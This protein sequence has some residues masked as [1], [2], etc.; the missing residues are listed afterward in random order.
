MATQANSMQASIW[1]LAAVL[2]VSSAAL[3]ADFARADGL[4]FEEVS[5]RILAS[6]ELISSISFG[7]RITD[8]QG[9]F[10]DLTIAAKS[11]CFYYCELGHGGPKFDVADDYDRQIV[12]VLEDRIAKY[13]PHCR[14]VVQEPFA[15]G[16]RLPGTL[17]NEIFLFATGIWPLKGRE[18]S[19]PLGHAHGLVDIASSADFTVQ[20]EAKEVSG[21]TC[22]LI[23]HKSGQDRLWVDLERGCC[24]TRREFYG[25]NGSS[26]SSLL[27]MTRHREVVPGVWIPFAIRNTVF[28]ASLSGTPGETRTSDF[29]VSIKYAEINNV[30]DEQFHFSPP[31]GTLEIL[32]EE[33]AHKTR[34]LVSGGYDLLDEYVGWIAKRTY[35]HSQ[36]N[37]S[38]F[39]RKTIA[40]LLAFACIAFFVWFF[41]RK[42]GVI[43]NLI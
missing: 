11:P 42:N 21:R 26:L 10:V 31:P 39:S 41:I 35:S 1:R 18:Y 17:Q 24:I 12:Y 16:D 33:G 27:Q 29:T 22:C 7:Y 19:A 37:H 28:N 20:R 3:Y 43:R 4:S 40:S 15:S 6:Q 23:A 13:R 30:A 9:L 5:R 38:A 2:L 14:T 32:P 36:T 25:K 34:Q 8:E